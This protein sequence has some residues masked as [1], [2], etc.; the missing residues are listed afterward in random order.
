MIHIKA[1]NSV[2]ESS[3]SVFLAG[4][5]EMGAA[6]DWQ[7]TAVSQ[8]ADLDVVVLNPRRE[9]WDASWEQ[10][11]TNPVFNEQ[12]TWEMDGLDTVTH[13]FFY[14]QPGTQSPITLAELGYVLGCSTMFGAISNSLNVLEPTIVVVCPQGF[15]RKGNVDIMCRRAG[16]VVHETL[17]QGLSF[18]CS[19]I[20][21]YL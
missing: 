19:D 17:D 11:E 2:P 7:Q 12:V 4:S 9:A 20:K 5:I 18:L 8:L 21:K 3:I 14:F 13:I 1:P 6:E 15:W 16:V 10:T